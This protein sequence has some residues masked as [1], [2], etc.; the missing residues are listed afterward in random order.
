MLLEICLL[1]VL[2]LECLFI[3]PPLGLVLS[4]GVLVLALVPTRLVVAWATH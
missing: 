1:E 4:R 3:E 2:L